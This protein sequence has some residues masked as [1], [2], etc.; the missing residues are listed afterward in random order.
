LA[1]SA[2]ILS[3]LFVGGTTSAQT[4]VAVL[5]IEAVDAPVNTA[6]LLGNA[7]K[8]RVR[9]TSGYKLVPGKD[10][11]EIKL[12][13]GCV[14]EKPACMS[15]AG[16]SLSAVKLL[17]GSLKKSGGALNLTLKWL[18][19][20]GARIEQFVSESIGKAQLNQTQANQV[21]ARVTRSILVSR[22]GM[23]KVTANI[24]G[25]QVMLGPRVIGLTDKDALVLRDVPSGTHLVRITK[26]GFRP[27]TQQVMVRGGQTTELDAELLAL[28]AGEEPDIPTGDGG[29]TPV[30]VKPPS[31]PGQGWKIAF[32]SSAAVTVGMG[33]A[34]GITGAQVLGLEEDKDKAIGEYRTKPGKKNAFEGDNVC[35]D[36]EIENAPELK[37][38]CDDGETKAV[39]TNV[40]IGVTLAAAAL[41]GFFY[42]KAYIAES[43]S[44]SPD[45]EAESE[46][47]RPSRSKI[48]WMVSPSAGP[49]GGGIG[50][51][52]RF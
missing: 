31:K 37:S 41:T 13:F 16:K 14:D 9:Q 33:V 23:I 45:T 49:D 26:D 39:L 20:P 12:V 34:I 10:L 44:S 21:V 52:M 17:W 35:E 3:I 8:N 51:F 47:S 15:R 36:P 32:W 30:V 29:E 50:F 2:V 1:T 38:I 19:V 18:D 4:P 43:S 11:D 22:N 46:A 25:A 27:W 6:A 7:L 42:Y 5:G 40:F 48:E 28:A 24:A